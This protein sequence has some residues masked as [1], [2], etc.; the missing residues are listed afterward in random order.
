MVIAGVIGRQFTRAQAAQTAELPCFHSL[1]Q[2]SSRFERWLV[3]PEANAVFLPG[4]LLSWWQGAPLFGFLQ[5]AAANWPLMS[6]LLYVVI[7]LL[8]PGV[9]LPRGKRFARALETAQG[10][11]TADLRAAFRD[12]IVRRAHVKAC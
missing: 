6:L 4:L 1:I 11:I 5:R 10:Q 3:I 7:Y 8:V 2:L 9:F 12:P